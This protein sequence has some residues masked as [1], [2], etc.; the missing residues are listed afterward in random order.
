MRMRKAEAQAQTD[1]AQPV[2]PPPTQ[3]ILMQDQLPN[4]QP[5]TRHPQKIHCQPC[6]QR[7]CHLALAVVAMRLYHVGVGAPLWV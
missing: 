7:R 5:A 2:I 4:S 6:S 1:A 3:H